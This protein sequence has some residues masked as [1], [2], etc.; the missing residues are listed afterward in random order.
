[1]PGFVG[2]LL[3]TKYRFRHSKVTKP[4]LVIAENGTGGKL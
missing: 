3:S 4:V 1:M 2:F